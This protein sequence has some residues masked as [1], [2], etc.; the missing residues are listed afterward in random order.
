M[1]NVSWQEP[2]IIVDTLALCLI[3]E[4]PKIACAAIIS[5][6]FSNVEITLRPGPWYNRSARNFGD[7]AIDFRTIILMLLKR[8]WSVHVAVLKYGRNRRSNLTKAYHR[9]EVDFLRQL[10]HFGARIHQIEDLHAKGIVTPFGAVSGSTNYTNSG[11]YRQLQNANYFAFDHSEY[12]GT[13]ER[14]L[15]LFDCSASTNLP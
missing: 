6:W 2:Q 5:P 12:K 11:M 1:P 14:L 8:S 15:S 10:D 13:K 7:G 4:S 3:E 9:H